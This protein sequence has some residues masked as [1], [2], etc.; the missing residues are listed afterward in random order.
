LAG[1]KFDGAPFVT[2][3]SPELAKRARMLHW[4]VL[5][6]QNAHEG[7]PVDHRPRQSSTKEE[8]AR[9]KERSV[10]AGSSCG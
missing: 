8:H 10:P 6:N 3:F 5:E 4:N 7:D 1:I 9:R 2:V